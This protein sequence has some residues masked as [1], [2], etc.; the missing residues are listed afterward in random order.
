MK[1]LI[2]SQ[3]CAGA[4]NSYPDSIHCAFLYVPTFVFHCAE[5]VSSLDTIFI[6]CT[7]SSP[8]LISLMHEQRL[9]NSLNRPNVSQEKTIMVYASL[10]NRPFS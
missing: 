9:I 8:D 6:L 4:L 1:Q 2:Y 10:R 5:K 7:N 3:R